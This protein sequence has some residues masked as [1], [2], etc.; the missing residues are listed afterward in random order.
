MNGAQSTASF[1]GLKTTANPTGRIT[2][3][4][5]VSSEIINY[6]RS[7]MSQ[8]PQATSRTVKIIFEVKT[9][10]QYR[11]GKPITQPPATGLY[12]YYRSLGSQ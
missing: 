1:T 2:L 5:A 8:T 12:N 6:M 7:S 10:P 11:D 4:P 9:T 3:T